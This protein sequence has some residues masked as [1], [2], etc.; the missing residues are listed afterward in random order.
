LTTASICYQNV[1]EYPGS[2]YGLKYVIFASTPSLSYLHPAE[3][4]G[5]VRSAPKIFL[6]PERIL[7]VNYFFVRLF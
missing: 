6:R 2:S 5:C 1:A 4:I 3:N 7:R